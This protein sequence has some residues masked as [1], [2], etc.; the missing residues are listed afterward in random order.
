VGVP[1]SWLSPLSCGTTARSRDLCAP[2]R[3][4]CIVSSLWKAR[5]LLFMGLVA[6]TFA[7]V[8]PASAGPRRLDAG[9][10]L[11]IVVPVG[12]HLSQHHFTPCADPVE[13]F[14]LI[15]RGA[16]L[17]V[18]ERFAREPAPARPSHFRVTGPARPMECCAIEGRAGWTFHF[19]DHGRAFYVYLYPGGAPPLPLLHALDSL[20]I[21]TRD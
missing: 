14:S 21:Q 17:T 6:V 16:I 1:R 2:L 15:D 8:R 5:G 4:T 7:L 13:R 19:R 9:H 3:R 11:T 10:G 12:A 20:R 18:E